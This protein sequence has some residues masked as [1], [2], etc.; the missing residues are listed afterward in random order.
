M[1]GFWEELNLGGI[2]EEGLSKTIDTAQGAIGAKL[3]IAPTG[4][5][6]QA[7]PEQV[8]AGDKPRTLQGVPVS[9]QDASRNGNYENRGGILMPVED[10]QRYLFLGVGALGIL[11]VAF[12]AANKRRIA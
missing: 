7:Y 10:T 5:P 6:S 8:P 1:A 3:G 12:I 9:N 4:E 2:L 11:A